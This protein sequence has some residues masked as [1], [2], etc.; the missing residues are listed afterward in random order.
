MSYV[1]LVPVPVNDPERD[2]GLGRSPRPDRGRARRCSSKLPPCATAKRRR[3]ARRSP[4]NRRTARRS[5][6]DRMDR[7]TA[8]P[9]HLDP[10]R[11]PRRAPH[12]D[13]RRRGPR[14]PRL[15]LGGSP[16][17][18]TE[19][20]HQRL[21]RSATVDGGRDAREARDVPMSDPV[22]QAETLRPMTAAPH[23]EP[24]SCGHQIHEYQADPRRAQQPDRH[25]PSRPP[26][27][28]QRAPRTRYKK[29][30]RPP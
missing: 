20:P 12:P 10:A 25:P 4:S 26:S 24:W 13:R 8:A 28:T 19:R 21:P 22:F 27:H 30:T 6:R 14:A 11:S 5:G 23:D 15:L 17:G 16:N 2:R 9:P 7:T 3:C 29:S 18:M 1:G